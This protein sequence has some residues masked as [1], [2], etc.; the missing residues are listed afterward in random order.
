MRK[1]FLP[2]STQKLNFNNI[3]RWQAGIAMQIHTLLLEVQIDT[4]TWKTIGS[5]LAK[6]EIGIH[7][8]Q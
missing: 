7:V 5:Y 2:S 6:L 3:K 4:P 1:H 8:I